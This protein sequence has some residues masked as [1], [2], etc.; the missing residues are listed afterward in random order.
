MKINEE[1]R[2][3][4]FSKPVILIFDKKICENA[5]S[6]EQRLRSAGFYDIELIHCTSSE[7][8]P[9]VTIC[10]SGDFIYGKRIDEFL[11]YARWYANVA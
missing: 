10:H 11:N 4:F 3:E 9:A 8:D 1:Y 2:R 5:G 7:G 6:L